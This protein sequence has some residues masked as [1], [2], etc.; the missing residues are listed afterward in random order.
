MASYSLVYHQSKLVK[1]HN[2][3]NFFKSR[4]KTP[5]KIKTIKIKSKILIMAHSKFKKAKNY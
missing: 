3:G 5:L 4:I 2:Q 1:D